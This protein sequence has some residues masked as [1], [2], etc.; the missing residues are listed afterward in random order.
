MA[1]YYLTEYYFNPF[2]WIGKTKGIPQKAVGWG[3][4][5]INAAGSCPWLLFLVPLAACIVPL[6]AGAME[7]PRVIH[8]TQQQYQAQNQNWSISQGLD[9]RMFFGNSS[10]LLM[11]DGANWRTFSRPGE[12]VIRAVATNSEGHV[13][14]G[15]YAQAGYWAPDEFGQ[16]NFHSIL[17]AVEYEQARKEEIWHFLPT[18]RGMFFQ[19]FSTLYRYDNGKVEVI[20]PPGNVMFIRE[21]GERIL[22]P[23]IHKGVYEYLPDGRFI[24]LPGSEML[25]GKQVATILPLERGG[26]LV[27]TQ[28]DGLY[29][30]A[31]GVLELWPAAVNQ[32]L[33]SAQVNKGIRLSNGNMAIGTILD[34]IYIISPNGMLLSHINQENG[35]QN[36]TVLALYEDQ[37][38]NLW[39]ALDKGIDLI[40]MDASLSFFSDKKGA[41]G[42]VFAAA[43]YEER[44]YIGTNHGVFFKSWPSKQ[45]DHFQLVSGSQGQAWE[46]KER[47]GLLF[48]AHNSGV[49]LVGENAV[50]ELYD[51]T[52]VFHILELPNRE[53]YLLL[54]TYTGLA[55]LRRDEQG[56]WAYAHTVKGFSASAK[57]AFFDPKGRLW[58]AHPHRGV[59][60]LRLND[61]LTEVSQ[62]PIPEPEGFQPLEK[63]SASIT[64]WDGKAYIWG[65]GGKLAFHT[66]T[67][68][69]TVVPEREAFPGYRGKE[70]WIPGLHGALFKAF[71][72]HAE[73]IDDGRHALLQVSLIPKDERIVS[74][75]DSL[76][77]IGTEDGYGIFNARR[78]VDKNELNLPEPILSAIEVKGRALEINAVNALAKPLTLQ[79]DEGGLRFLFAMPFYIQNV[80]LRYRL[81][82]FE[83]G[84]SDFSLEHTKEYTNLPP[85]QYVFQVQSELSTQLKPF[86]FEVAPYWYQAAWI[87]LLALGF[88]ILLGRLLFRFHENRMD[89]QRRRLEVQKQRALQR[90]RVYSKNERLR[91]EVD[92]IS[93][94]VAD[95]TMELVRKNEMLIMLKKELKLL[96]KKKGP[97]NSTHHLQKMIRQIDSHLSSEEDWNVFEANFNQLHDQFFKRLKAEFPVLTPGDLRLAAYLKMNLASKEI[98]PLLN[99]SLRGV[100]NK[101]YRLRRKMQ[102]ES[103]DN[104]TEFLMQF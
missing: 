38:H 95:S 77:L 3:V 64:H 101:R 84:W 25:A 97:E 78:A 12:R 39:A 73:F 75:N 90:Q 34:G 42:S 5:L 28:D 103:D 63:I 32:E 83:E 58:V 47:D 52:G 46:L 10:G 76:Y 96:Q 11:Y 7:V 87:K 20:T 92:S 26:L 72:H 22:V 79:P 67:E 9:K 27:A 94:K 14:V 41:L 65:G 35:L 81:Q 40:V 98:A 69:I 29:R 66:R 4:N 51:A 55:V 102:L 13:F 68:Q 6:S 44:L 23:V 50:T 99:I 56:A 8:F 19:S 85:G 48:C 31:D 33:A 57:D 18:N 24:L 82:G 70:K 45:R 49:F 71:P 60:C 16:F 54:A 89:R 1:K 74:L 43:L 37:A 93:R 91:A 2:G 53:G 61:D 100:E 17:D 62:I 30:Y 80:N 36:N 104:L 86:S 21:V 59:Y 15:G 88:F